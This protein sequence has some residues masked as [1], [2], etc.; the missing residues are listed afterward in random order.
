MCVIIAN[1][2]SKNVLLDKDMNVQ[3]CDFSDSAAIPLGSDISQAVHYGLSV[4]TNIFQFGSLMYEVLTRNAFNYD[5][6]V[7]K[8]VDAQK[9]QC[10]N[11]DWQAS[12]VWTRTEDL[13][14]TKRL[15]LRHVVLRCWTGVYEH[16][17][18]VCKAS[19]TAL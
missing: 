16:M 7:N 4:K 18:E 12:A 19:K 2:A 8:D 3:L 10:G 14:S 9:L 1:I 6:L 11:E 15:L 5:L 13:P 17:G